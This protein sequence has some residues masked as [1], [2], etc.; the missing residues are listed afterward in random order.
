MKLQ[1]K[2]RVPRIDIVPL[3]DVLCFMLIFFFIFSTFKSAQTGVEVDLPKTVHL[4]QTEQNTVVISIDHNVQVFFGEEPVSMA[5]LGDR[6]AEELSR[7]RETRFIVKPD[8]SVP[9]RAIIAVT[10]ALASFGVDKPL[11]GVDRQQ[12]PHSA[13]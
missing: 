6:I 12:M 11:W 9:Y 10:D 1:I 13:E 5:V 8:A 7:N 3:I 4:G 2:R